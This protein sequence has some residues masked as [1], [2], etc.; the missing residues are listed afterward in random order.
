MSAGKL[1]IAFQRLPVARRGRILLALRVKNIADAAM[2]PGAVRL[3]P[4]RFLETSNR[5]VVQAAAAERGAK[6]EMIVWIVL[7][8]AN[9]LAQPVDRGVEFSRLVRAAA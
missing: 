4:Q 6:I 8:V 1:R 2:C 9:G 5:L 7:L 3:E